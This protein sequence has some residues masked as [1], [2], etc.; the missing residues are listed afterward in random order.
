M[1]EGFFSF[2]KG[3]L[4][5]KNAS[6][7][8]VHGERESDILIQDGIITELG[9]G[10][11]RNVDVQINASGFIV[12]PG[13][14][15]IHFHIREPGKPYEEDISSGTSAAVHGG[16]T[17]LFMM[18]NTNP[19]IDNPQIVSFVVKKAYE[20]SRTRL[21]PTGCATEE[22]K[23]E[24]IAEYGLMKKEGIIAVT[25]DGRAVKSS[26]AMRKALEYSKNFSLPVIEHP[27]DPE[28]SGD[29]N[30]G[31][32]TVK[33]GISPY[34]P[35]AEEIIVARD[36]ILALHTDAHIHFTHISTAGSVEIIKIAKEKIVKY[37]LK[38]KITCDVTPHHILM[39]ENDVDITNA[40]FK[41]NPP[42]RSEKDRARLIEAIQEGIIDCI[43]SDHAPHPDFEKMKDFSSAPPGFSC[44]DIFLPLCFKLVSEEIISLSKLTELISYNP[45]KIFGLNCGEI[46]EG[47]WGDIVIFDP[48]KEFVVSEKVIFS[49][50]KNSPYIGWKLKGLVKKTIVAGKVVYDL[51]EFEGKLISL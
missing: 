3:S 16:I 41:V 18:P 31:I 12:I 24:K 1:H 27:E 22:R 15:D 11:K 35:A 26:F 19:P 51:D 48:D 34:S 4:L 17:T 39:T 6:I 47:K 37:G 46:R 42:L 21:Y 36:T 8:D 50:G 38:A 30:E 2:G 45:A 33:F 29:A 28:L 49:K 7:V 40:N 5:I 43:A 13:A 25:D 20:K 44:A 9:K 10:L 32:L 14:V 23:G